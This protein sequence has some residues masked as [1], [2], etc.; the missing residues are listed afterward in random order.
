MIIKGKLIG[1][2]CITSKKGTDCFFGWL[3][4]DFPVSSG[5]VGMK[6]EQLAAFAGDSKLISDKVVKLQLVDKEVT[7]SGMRQ[8]NS[9]IVVDV[10]K[11]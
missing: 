3:L 10:N 9:F 4:T 6:C 1:Y 7:C 8:G 5:G 2:D 11:A